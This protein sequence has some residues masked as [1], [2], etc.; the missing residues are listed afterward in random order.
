MA[1]R[2]EAWIAAIAR[3]IR[4]SWVLSE[5][6]GIVALGAAIAIL[7]GMNAEVGDV[8]ERPKSV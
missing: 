6:S 3:P 8:V 4:S 5:S 7:V 2:P 1:L